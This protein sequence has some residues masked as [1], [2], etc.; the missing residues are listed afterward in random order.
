MTALIRIIIWL[1]IGIF[2]SIGFILCIPVFILGIV[3]GSAR[4]GFLISKYKKE[5]KHANT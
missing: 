5:K 1:F 4:L 3:F 2:A